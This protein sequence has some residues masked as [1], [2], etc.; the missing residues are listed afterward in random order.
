MRAMMMFVVFFVMA[1]AMVYGREFQPTKPSRTV[2]DDLSQWKT[3]LGTIT[4]EYRKSIETVRKYVVIKDD[5]IIPVLK[6]SDTV[7]FVRIKSGN[8]WYY[9]RMRCEDPAVTPALR[10]GD[11]SLIMWKLM[12]EGEFQ[13]VPGELY[14]RV[15]SPLYAKCRDVAEVYAVWVKHRTKVPLLKTWSETA[16]EYLKSKGIID[17]DKPILVF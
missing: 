9:M 13:T 10:E 11:N 17:L 3:M 6:V 1:A 16:K 14:N 8:A 2:P 4:D 5:E 15:D 12:Y 7:L